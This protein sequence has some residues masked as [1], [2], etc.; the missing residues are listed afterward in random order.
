[1]RHVSK[2]LYCIKKDISPKIIIGGAVVRRTKLLLFIH[3]A[4]EGGLVAQ[5]PLTIRSLCHFTRVVIMIQNSQ[6]DKL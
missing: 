6:D 3:P 4:A 5:S 2:T 1:M